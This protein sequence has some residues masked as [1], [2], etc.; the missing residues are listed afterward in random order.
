M[1]GPWTSGTGGSVTS[2]LFTWARTGSVAG[3][4]R[5]ALWRALY[6]RLKPPNM[7]LSEWSKHFRMNISRAVRD[8]KCGTAV[9][10]NHFA[11]ETWDVTQTRNVHQS[12]QRMA[13]PWVAEFDSSSFQG[14][15]DQRRVMHGTDSPG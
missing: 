11:A 5:N 4:C 15:K 12:I 10:M 8:S 14:T 2:Y 9:I 1:N 3:R 7:H 6:R 13:K